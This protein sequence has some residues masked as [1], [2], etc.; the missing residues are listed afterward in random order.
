MQRALTRIMI[1]SIRYPDPVI[2]PMDSIK[3]DLASGK[4][5]GHVKFDTGEGIS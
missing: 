4:I 1:C 5:T 2:K 3:I